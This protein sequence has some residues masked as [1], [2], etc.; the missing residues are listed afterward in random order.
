ML[1]LFSIDCSLFIFSNIRLRSIVHV[2]KYPCILN[3]SIRAT[4]WSFFDRIY[5]LAREAT[6]F[7]SNRPSRQLSRPEFWSSFVN[8]NNNTFIVSSFSFC[9]V[10]VK[11]FGFFV[12]FF[13]FRFLLC[14]LFNI[15]LT[16]SKTWSF[17]F[18]STAVLILVLLSN[19]VKAASAYMAFIAKYVTAF[20]PSI[21]SMKILF[22]CIA[23]TSQSLESTTDSLKLQNAQQDFQWC[24]SQ[25]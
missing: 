6:K 1:Y 19:N 12:F 5:T 4:D 21:S 14:F 24:H 25:L 2:F 7:L 9:R 15:L 3:A 22:A 20:S 17:L 18:F 10:H 23:N 13:Y 11:L 8:I 16:L